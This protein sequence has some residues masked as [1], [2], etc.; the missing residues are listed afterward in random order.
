MTK[1]STSSGAPLHKQI[2]AT[3]RQWIAEGR[4]G[5][6]DQLPPAREMS[7]SCGIKEQT[8]RRALKRLIDEGVLKGAQ[9]KGV[10]VSATGTKHKRVALVLPNL[11]DELTRQ[12]ARGTQDT[13]DAAGLQTFILDAG[14]DSAKEDVHIVDLPTLPIDGAIIFPISYGDIS[15]HILRLKDAALP[16]VLID[17]YFP[18]IACD[19]VL[20]DDYGGTY[21]L[22][23]ELAQRGYR[24]FGWL[25]GEAGSTTVENR[26]EGFRWALG[27]QGIPIS[28]QQVR[29][30]K[31]ET[32]TED[33]RPKVAVEI[34]A[35]L[36]LPAEARPEIIVCSNDLIA[37]ET[38]WALRQRGLDVP[39]DIGVTGFDDSKAALESGLTSVQKSITQMGSKA[40]E[41]LLNRL[42]RKSAPPERVVL[43]TAPVFRHSTERQ[44]T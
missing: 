22:T 6:G 28:R 33:F 43:P 1:H 30:L 37:L 39:G 3:V 18:G 41:L 42:T 2:E 19:C 44:T 14:R 25:S 31:L 32:P 8:V 15:E 24:R 27:D 4:Y 35:L 38:M 36:A 26:L 7:E 13:L 34:D 17:K 12:I 29:R 20:A 5:A 9:G 23:T 10:F 21:A 16:F 40:A 11:E